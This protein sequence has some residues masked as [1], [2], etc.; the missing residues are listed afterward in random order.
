MATVGEVLQADSF[1]GNADLGGAISSPVKIDTNPLQQLALYTNFYNKTLYEQTI[2]DRNAKIAEVSK[3][4]DINLNNVWGKDKQDMTDSLNQLKA[5]AAEYAKNP[6]RSVSDELDWQT[7]I[8]DVMNKYNSAKQRAL[9]YNQQY[10]DINSGADPTETKQIKIDD[11]NKRFDQTGIDTPM[12]LGTGY[13]PVNINL[14]APQ[15]ASVDVLKVTDNKNLITS[16]KVTYFDPSANSAL[17][18]NAIIGLSS[19]QNGLS[20]V[21]K[22]LQNTAD[23]E[24]QVWA[25]MKDAFNSVLASKNSDGSY[26]YFDANN[27]FLQDKFETDNASNTAIMT[28]YKAMQGMNAYS[29]QK[30][31][32]INQGVFSDGGINYHAPAT[33]KTD[34]FKAGLINFTPD[35]IGA[36]K[37]ALAG[38]YN[39]YLGDA[40]DKK[41]T[42]LGLGIEQQN[43]NSESSNAAVKWANLKLDKDKWKASQ[44]VGTDAMQN[45]A[46]DKAKRIYSEMA[47]L[48]DKNGVI[49]PDKVRQL[50]VEQLKYLGVEQPTEVDNNGVKTQVSGYKPLSLTDKNGN[51]LPV[52]IQLQNGQIK[53]L[54]NAQQSESG[55]GSYKGTFDPTSSTNITNMATNILNEQVKNASGKQEDAS[56]NSV[57]TS[58]NGEQQPTFSQPT[59]KTISSGD[60]HAKAS[61]AGYSD[62][63]YKRIL[64]KNGIKIIE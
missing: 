51:V 2:A 31:N 21:D 39:K 5:K 32:E 36:D 4:A 55:S 24:A 26:K 53:V 43:A 23:G 19:L 15:T 58:A 8:G 33:I 16:N 25:G 44:S 34:N 11:L 40:N 7:S 62:A 56:Y 63:E 61:A 18:S 47:A 3:V 10:N 17:A 57:N 49:S 46:L 9:V 30:I 22:N 29:Q 54:K 64:I 59:K 1:G 6:N 20:G 60:I 48:A 27:K 28:P 50:N 42:K 52:A 41:A 38:I 13:K 35:G 12:T 37:L 14:P 45:T